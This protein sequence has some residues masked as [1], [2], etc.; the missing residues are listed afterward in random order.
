MHLLGHKDYGLMQFHQQ[1]PVCLIIGFGFDHTT[2]DYKVVVICQWHDEEMAM[3]LHWHLRVYN[4]ASDTWRTVYSLNRSDEPHPLFKGSFPPIPQI[5][6]DQPISHCLLNGVFHWACYVGSHHDRFDA[7]LAFDMASDVMQLMKAPPFPTP[8]G[9]Y[10]SVWVL[11]DTIAAVSYI[12]EPQKDVE[13]WMMMEY[14]VDDSWVMLFKFHGVGTWTPVGF[15]YDDRV[16]FDDE[17]GH[18]ISSDI[19]KDHKV[20]EHG[21]YGLTY[22]T[23]YGIRG[24]P[25]ILD[26]VETLNTLKPVPDADPIL[27]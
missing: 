10:W 11:K 2:N 8:R 1:Q 22:S 20:K 18:L 27:A 13:L 9:V 23:Y 6:P 3:D 16:F 19:D 21:V 17:S 5:E 12:F 7:V 15:P 4:H 14:G 25:G 26:Y 24:T